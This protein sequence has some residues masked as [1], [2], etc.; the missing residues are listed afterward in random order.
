MINACSSFRTPAVTALSIAYL[1]KSLLLHNGKEYLRGA[2]ES[3][4]QQSHT[5]I[6]AAC[7]CREIIIIKKKMQQGISEKNEK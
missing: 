2:L 1:L 5:L 3:V 7:V 6:T 4:K